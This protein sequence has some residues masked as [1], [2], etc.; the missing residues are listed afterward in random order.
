MREDFERELERV[1]EKVWPVV[2]RYLKDPVFP[3]QFA[4]GEEYKEESESSWRVVREYPE[5]KGKYGRAALMILAAG[6]MGASEE[7]VYLSAGAMQM[8]EDWLLI[9]DDFED[10][11]MFRRGGL[12]LQ[13]MYGEKLAVNAGDILHAVMWKAL[14]DNRGILGQEKTFLIMDEFYRML[15]RTALGQAVEIKWAEKGRKDFDDE[16]WYFVADGKTG[17]Y[18]MALPL[19]VGGIIAGANDEQLF[20]MTRFGRSLGRCFQLVDDILDLTSDFGG[21]KKQIGNDIYEGKK[22]LISGHLQRTLKGKTRKRLI[23]IMGKTREEKSEEEV[24]WVI[25]LMKSEGSIAYAREL[26]ERHAREA[27]ECFE[28]NL[29]FLKQEP[30]RKQIRGAISFFLK[31]NH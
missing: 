30:Y 17:Y 4:V 21:L 15:L 18:T 16:D 29:G 24:A 3:E 2:E 23:G 12:A 22:T 28:R 7:K 9:H 26:A 27:E 5:R 14:S 19:R 8:S 10:G 11:S 31:R 25:N 20:L 6:A 1:K 13:R